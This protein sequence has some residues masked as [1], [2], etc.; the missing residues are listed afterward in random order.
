MKCGFGR[1]L[2]FLPARIRYD[3]HK[4]L[5]VVARFLQNYREA[6]IV[7]QQRYLSPHMVIHPSQYSSKHFL[8]YIPPLP[9]SYL[10]PPC[11]AFPRASLSYMKRLPTNLTINTQI[12]SSSKNLS[13]RV[14][15]TVVAT[16]TNLSGLRIEDLASLA[17][18]VDALWLA[19][20]SAEAV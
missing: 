5:E 12:N 14:L 11:D 6:K 2:R 19:G 18:S 1:S 13:S 7:H 15:G 16:S 9:R 4:M 20:W 3:T 8:S 10:R 17:G